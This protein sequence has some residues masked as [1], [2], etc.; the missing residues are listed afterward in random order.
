MKYCNV[1]IP[2]FWKSN[3][4]ATSNTGSYHTDGKNL[5]SYS[6]LIGVT[7]GQSK[8][9]FDY[10]GN[11][12]ISQTTSTHVGYAR[13][14]ADNIIPPEKSNLYINFSMSS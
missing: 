11:N 13:K 2:N 6:K 5:Y 8:I 14:W 10:S 4:P 12:F 3:T 7:D 9:L 1:D